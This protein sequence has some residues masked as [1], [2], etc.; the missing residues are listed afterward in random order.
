MG[1]DAAL[2]YVGKLR[3]RTN[4]CHFI[5][6]VTEFRRW[7]TPRDLGIVSGWVWKIGLNRGVSKG[8]SLV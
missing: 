1:G 4:T 3:R 5:L 6:G 8:T 2:L 7:K